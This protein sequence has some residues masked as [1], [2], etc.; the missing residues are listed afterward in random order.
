MSVLGSGGV[1]IQ[2]ITGREARMVAG[3]SVAYGTPLVAGVTPGKAGESVAGVPVFDSVKDAIHGTGGAID[4]SLISVPPF[5]VLA[6][7]REA[8]D[9]GIRRLVIATENVPR[10]DIVRLL[11]DADERGCVVI[12][13]NSVGTITPRDRRKVGAIGG[14]RPERA[15]VPGHAGIISR[16]GG[17]TSEIGLTLRRAGLGVSTAISVGGDDLIGLPPEKAARLLQSDPDTR[18]LCVFGEPGTAFEED[19]A[20]AMAAGEVTVPVVALIAGLFTESLPEGT[21]FGHAAA[22]IAGDAGRPSV[23]RRMLAD[24][25]GYVV[26]TLDE[27]AEVVTDI[28]R[29][30]KC[31]RPG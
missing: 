25:G 29:S 5:A 23:K 21:A 31:E 26:E 16:S 14:D 27:L 15:F 28:L 24:A 20:H 30:M 13:P 2:G 17:M 10:H 8:L 9:S 18:V 1:I 4:T 19:L 22:I 12:G 6:A 7:G 11:A 3:H